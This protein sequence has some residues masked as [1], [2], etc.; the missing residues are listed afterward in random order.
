MEHIT[1]GNTD[2]HT[3]RAILGTMTFGT[4]T[5]ESVAERMMDHCL[6]RGVTFFDTANVYSEGRSEEIIGRWMK[7]RREQVLI[8]SKV[9]IRLGG[10]GEAP[11]LT[12]RAIRKGIEG[13]LRR[14]HTDYIDL[15]YLHTPDYQTPMEE[16]LMVMRDLVEEGKVRYLGASNY[17]SWQ[18][19]RLLWLAER[20]NLPAVRVVQPMYNLISRG[21]EQ[22][23]LPMCGEFGLPTVAYNP[24]AGGLLTGKQRY[25]TTVPGSR[26]DGNDM[27]R[28]RYWYQVNFEAVDVLSGVARREGISLVQLALRWLLHHSRIDAVIL[29]ASRFEHLSENLDACEAGPLDDESVRFCDEVW[30]MLKGVSPSYNR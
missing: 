20:E 29:G 1:L 22:E 24:L 19:C 25:E 11:G 26:F 27:Y 6:E 5:E 15:Y 4:Q 18:L 21:I 3:S 10:M 30:H 17:A 8:A 13:S 7:G 23:L 14:L 12:S 28:A 2:L 16:T 9:G